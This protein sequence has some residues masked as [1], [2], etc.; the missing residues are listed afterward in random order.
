M[1]DRLPLILNSRAEAGHPAG[2]KET[3]GLHGGAEFVRQ[4]GGHGDIGLG[5]L[6]CHRPH[7]GDDGVFLCGGEIA[8][9]LSGVAQSGAGVVPALLLAGVDLGV[10]EVEVVKQSRPGRRPGVPAVVPGD[11]EGDV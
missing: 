2:P 1:T 5:A 4:D 10:V 6:V 8:A 3:E 7:V 9:E 11:A